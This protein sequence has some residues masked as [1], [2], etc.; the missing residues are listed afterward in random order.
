MHMRPLITSK[1][2][3]KIRRLALSLGIAEVLLLHQQMISRNR[4]TS[5]GHSPL[6]PSGSSSVNLS[7]ISASAMERRNITLDIV[8]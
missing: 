6:P 3:Q 8:T 5:V 4:H 7:L 2:V 1:I